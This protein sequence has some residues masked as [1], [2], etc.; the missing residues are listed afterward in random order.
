MLHILAGAVIGA[1]VGGAASAI[2]SLVKGEPVS[3]K[4][5]GA[6]ALGGA[7]AGSVASLTFGA[8]LLAGS[9]AT[10][11][12]GMVAA[13]AVGGATEQVTDN[14]L[15]DDPW[16]KD[17]G[18]SAAIGGAFGA[19]AGVGR[20]AAKPF[21]TL[22]RA[23]AGR[24]ANAGRSAM[25]AVRPHAR[26]LAS[27][28]TGPIRRAAQ[29]VLTPI[30]ES[31]K[32]QA[33]RYLSPVARAARR[34][35]WDPLRRRVFDPL[36]RTLEPVVRPLK[37]VFRPLGRLW[38]KYRRLLDTHP[39]RTKA[40]TSAS[41]AM[42]G[43]VIGQAVEGRETWDWRR[44]L[45][46]GGFAALWSGPMGHY[47]FGALDK[48]IPGNAWG[49]V[50]S[51]IAADQLLWAP[52][53]GTVFFSSY[54]LIY[55][56]MT[57]AETVERVKRD[58]PRALKAQ[59]TVWPVFHLFNFRAVPLNMR[60]PASA[61]AGL[62]W[63]VFF[64]TLLSD[65][66]ESGAEAHDGHARHQIDGPLGESEARVVHITPP[67]PAE[68]DGVDGVT[69]ADEKLSAFHALGT[70]YGMGPEDC[71]PAGLVEGLGFTK[72]MRGFAPELMP[73]R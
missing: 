32:R 7:V 50:L 8:G 40:A 18:E 30:S 10:Q 3:W 19:V 58:L 66:E 37:P 28:A 16:H 65:D 72:A 22:M 46:R 17:V 56:G 26:Q 4:K 2:G 73:Q 27:R 11:V 33:S 20:V 6:A 61:T 45:F 60:V 69:S 52:V 64:S 67:R 5:V 41:I 36:A 71:F 24:L 42:T 49:A 9:A 44:T 53:S 1:V 70:S 57:P 15:H 34:R 39:V 48:V 25:N 54:S 59:Y 51:K 68:F 55:D 62:G 21:A 23:G 12:G 38:K 63:S 14:V 29:R 43:D 13:G 31:V 47:W 35:V